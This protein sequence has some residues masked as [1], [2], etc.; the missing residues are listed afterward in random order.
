MLSEY[1]Q[2]AMRR[3]EYKTLEDG[4]FFGEI[5]GFQGVWANTDALEECKVEL[6]EVLEE[7]LLLQIADG[8]ELPVLDGVSLARKSEVA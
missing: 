4:T 3:A 7:W 1:L 5:P 2:A 6:R 8:N